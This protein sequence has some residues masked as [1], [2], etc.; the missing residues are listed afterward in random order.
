M[1]KKA[2][3][4]CILALLFS[5]TLFSPFQVHAQGQAQSE[6]TCSY[7]ALKDEITRLQT[8]VIPELLG[9]LD[10]S[11][12]L[13]WPKTISLQSVM[14]MFDQ[15]NGT[16][17]K[18]A[19]A[20]EKLFGNL[21]ELGTCVNK[22]NKEQFED[23][24]S[25]VAKSHNSIIDNL[26]D[27]YKK[28]ADDSMLVKVNAEFKALGTQFVNMQTGNY[29][30]F[31]KEED[32]L[33]S[34]T[35]AVD[36]FFA[37]VSTAED[38]KKIFVEK[39]PIDLSIIPRALLIKSIENEFSG[40]FSS[41]IS[42]KEL[43]NELAN[44][45]ATIIVEYNF[46]EYGSVITSVIRVRE[47][48][49]MDIMPNLYRT[50]NSKSMI[51]K[52]SKQALFAKQA[53]YLFNDQSEI[54]ARHIL[55]YTESSANP[56]KEFKDV[57]TNFWAAKEIGFLANLGIINGFEGGDFKPDAEVTKAQAA[58]ML[59]RALK[60][61]VSNRPDPKYSDLPKSHRAYKEVAAL[62]D[63]GI[64]SGGSKFNPDATL[65]RSE[66][67]MML[68]K[69]YKL[70]GHSGIEFSD[71]PKKHIAYSHIQALAANKITVGVG[72]G[73]FDPNGKFEQSSVLCIYG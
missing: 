50:S 68:Q 38:L 6:T 9:E 60:L 31:L 30:L 47:L 41:Y 67:A 56:D 39:K 40:Y 25:F 3:I 22:K 11:G 1:C 37:Q 62:V 16:K 65:L 28:N 72:K 14:N 17:A 42:S 70:K 19:D 66:M 5:S 73:A 64:V 26:K 4:C 21:K 13:T 46:E 2:L 20:N 15:G 27:F 58:M 18:L 24:L 51:T 12:G 48:I 32:E 54:L 63:E 49:L 53:N 69:A 55:A 59:V 10:E 57:A 34:L 35:Y 36:T 44:E 43:S 33:K 52:T 61:D 29:F 71:V 8:K 23:Y 7:Q 45:L